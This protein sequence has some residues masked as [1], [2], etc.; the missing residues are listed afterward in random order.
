MVRGFLSLLSTNI[1]LVVVRLWP[2]GTRRWSRAFCPTP[3]CPRRWPRRLPQP[4]TLLPLPLP[5]STAL[6]GVS[7]STTLPRTPRTPFSGSSSAHSGRCKVSR[8]SATTLRASAK[9]SASSPW[10]TTKK[11]WLQS[12]TSTASP[13]AIACCKSRSNPTVG[14]RRGG[15]RDPKG[16]WGREWEAGGIKRKGE[17]KKP[18]RRTDRAAELSRNTHHW[19]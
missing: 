11:L 1:V 15:E 6:A 18:R 5:P 14:S 10:P 16:L 3:S 19:Q 17:K 4:P 8:S 7:S 9:A 13:S 12:R 2:T